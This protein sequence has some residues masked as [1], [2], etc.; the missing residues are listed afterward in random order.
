MAKRWL[1]WAFKLALT[2][3]IIWFL[4]TRIDLG[5]AARQ[6]AT[7]RP[8]MLA[9]AVVLMLLQVLISAVRWQAVL[10]AIGALLAFRQVFEIFYIG[11]FF[12]IALPSSV[13][14]DAVRMWKSRRAGLSLSG[15]VNGVMLERVVTVFGLVLMVAVTQPLLLRRLPDLPGTWVFPVLT[16]VALAGIVGLMLLDSLPATLRRWAVVRGL[17]HLAQDSRRLFLIPRN[18]TL[19]LVWALLGHVNLAL[20]VLVLAL[21][22]DLGVDIVDCLVLVPP[23]ILITT[24]PISIAGWGVREMAMVTAFGFVGVPPASGLALSVL[25]GLVIVVTSLPGGVLWLLSGAGREAEQ[26]SVRS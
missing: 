23:V 19:S 21:G 22:L 17:G 11:V 12:N 9:L 10:R 15:A 6:A 2:A 26:S 1:P 16:L 7:I 3:A 25:F 18:A 4:A 13:G 20:T 24:L 8:D 5:D 14:G